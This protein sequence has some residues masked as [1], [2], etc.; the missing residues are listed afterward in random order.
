[1]TLLPYTYQGESFDFTDPRFITALFGYNLGLVLYA[2]LFLLTFI[3]VLFAP[4]RQALFTIVLFLTVVFLY[5]CWWYWPI[6]VRALVDFYILPAIP[7]VWLLARS[8]GRR[9]T[10]V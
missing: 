7:L 5:S 6:L 1:G 2:P 3:G 10:V 4:R 8:R 9:R